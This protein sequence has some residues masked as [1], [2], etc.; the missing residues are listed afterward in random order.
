[1]WEPGTPFSW[2]DVVA[3]VIREG[4]SD[5]VWKMDRRERNVEMSWETGSVNQMWD[6][7][8]WAAVIEIGLEIICE[9]EEVESTEP[10]FP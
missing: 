2:S 3:Y 1:M 7:D 5:A 4:V 6:D 8:G 10:W 9:T